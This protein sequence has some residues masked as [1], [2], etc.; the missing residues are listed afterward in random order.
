[1]S[2]VVCDATI[3][4]ENHFLSRHS[5]CRSTIDDSA[6]NRTFH[7]REKGRGKREGEGEKERERERKIERGKK[8]EKKE[9]GGGRET[10]NRFVT[11]DRKLLSKL[12]VSDNSRCSISFFLCVFVF[13]GRGGG[14]P[15][16]LRR[17]PREA[18]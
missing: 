5:A 18:L 17:I 9:G 8:E 16:I 10:M 15:A 14:H 12:R 11:I 2:Q 4:R 6:V 13:W 7:V 3:L 1:M